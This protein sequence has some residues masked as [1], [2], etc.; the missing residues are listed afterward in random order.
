MNISA[1]IAEYL[2]KMPC[3]EWYPESCL[4]YV[5]SKCPL[6]SQH[7]QEVKDEL[8]CQLLHTNTVDN[9]SV[10]QW[11]RNKATRLICNFD[12]MFQTEEITAIFQELDVKVF[13]IY[14]LR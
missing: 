1:A 9:V 14:F 8:K 12:N 4:R 5:T 6:S 11:A 10:S 2:R 13:V 3:K 7:E